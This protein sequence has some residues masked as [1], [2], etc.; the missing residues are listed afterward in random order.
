MRTPYPA[1]LFEGMQTNPHKYLLSAAALTLVLVLH[2]PASPQNLAGQIAQAEEVAKDQEASADSAKSIAQTL[3]SAFGPGE[4]VD[5]LFSA[6]QQLAAAQPGDAAAI[7]AATPRPTPP[8]PQ[9]DS[10]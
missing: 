9:P 6:A 2:S 7:A 5:A 4:D 10:Q 8:A 1:T 3:G